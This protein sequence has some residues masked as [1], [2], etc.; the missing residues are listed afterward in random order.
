MD[1]IIYNSSAKVNYYVLRVVLLIFKVLN[2]VYLIMLKKG[3]V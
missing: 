1:K 3:Y 2:C